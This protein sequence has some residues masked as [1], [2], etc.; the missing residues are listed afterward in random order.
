MSK[1]LTRIERRQAQ[2]REFPFRRDERQSAVDA[3]PQPAGSD[4]LDLAHVAASILPADDR[5]FE[6]GEQHPVD[7]RFTDTERKSPENGVI[8]PQHVFRQERHRD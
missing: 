8:D 4:I 1:E 5:S 7:G 2:S 3:M 6:V